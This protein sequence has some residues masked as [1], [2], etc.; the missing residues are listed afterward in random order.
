MG[1]TDTRILMILFYTILLFLVIIPL[2]LLPFENS[3]WKPLESR[4]SMILDTI[5]CYLSALLVNRS[6]CNRYL[7]EFSKFGDNSSVVCNILRNFTRLRN[8]ITCQLLGIAFPP[9]N[10]R[11]SG[12]ARSGRI[13]LFFYSKKIFNHYITLILIHSRKE[14]FLWPYELKN[15]QSSFWVYLLSVLYTCASE[16]QKASPWFMLVPS[17]WNR[18]S[19]ISPFSAQVSFSNFSFSWKQDS[20]IANLA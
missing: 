7:A 18:F 5:H 4:R 9:G 16:H 19:W 10:G 17:M 15:E 2:L 6:S 3:T 11:L 1:A 8:F 20:A 14:I 13:R 12:F